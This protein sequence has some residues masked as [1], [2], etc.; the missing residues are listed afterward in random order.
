VRDPA[1]APK[2]HYNYRQPPSHVNFCDAFEP[3]ERVAT[4]RQVAAFF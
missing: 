1:V 4:A 2:D 3:D